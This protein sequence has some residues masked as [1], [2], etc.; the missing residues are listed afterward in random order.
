MC[1]FMKVLMKLSFALSLRGGE[2]RRRVTDYNEARRGLEVK[3]GSKWWPTTVV[4]APARNGSKVTLIIVVS[5]RPNA[6][7]SGSALQALE[8]GVVR[9]ASERKFLSVLFKGPPRVCYPSLGPYSNVTPANSSVFLYLP[10]YR[11]KLPCEWL[12]YDKGGLHR[13]LCGADSFHAEKAMATQRLQVTLHM[14]P[15]AS[16]YM[17]K[18]AGCVLVKELSVHF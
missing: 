16:I 9:Q 11:I 14:Q 5:G 15:I 7:P 1:T 13:I 12:W 6:H 8:L 2:Q 3:D 17:R 10:Q 18:I 4:D